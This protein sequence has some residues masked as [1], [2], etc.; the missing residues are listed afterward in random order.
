MRPKIHIETEGLESQL[1]KHLK[2]IIREKGPLSE[3]ELSDEALSFF[4]P[5]KKPLSA[6]LAKSYRMR[7]GK[8]IGARTADINLMNHFR[9]MVSDIKKDLLSTER[10][11]YAG[12]K[13]IGKIFYSKGQEG[14]IH[15]KVRELILGEACIQSDVLK[16][17]ESG[18]V[19]VTPGRKRAV[20]LL[21]HYGLAESR[22]I[23]GKNHAVK[24]GYNPVKGDF[25]E[26]KE[27]F[28]GH[29]K[30]WKPFTIETWVIRDGPEKVKLQF[31]A[32]AW[33]PVN[34]MFL[35]AMEGEYVSVGQV[36]SFREKG[37]L[38]GLPAKMVVFC[39]ELSGGAREYA[40]KWGIEI[41]MLR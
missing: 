8:K 25:E 28:P 31:N 23:G 2:E 1:R 36:R 13:R 39:K 20:G 22:I 5:Q 19:P 12:R 32:A 30:V 4:A 16:G 7:F 29:F 24:P 26:S 10:P 6:K 14:K 38:L 33:D 37:I 34:R 21:S 9:L 11:V 41:K 15:A 3:T 18:P 17:I 40:G 35:L 27:L